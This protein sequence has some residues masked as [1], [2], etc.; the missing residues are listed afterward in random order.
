[1]MAGL[2]VHEAAWH[3][4]FCEAHTVAPSAI[5]IAVRTRP[6]SLSRMPE[7]MMRMDWGGA[8][9]GMLREIWSLRLSTVEEMG[10]VRGKEIAGL[11]SLMVRSMVEDICRE[12]GGGGGGGG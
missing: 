10:T 5:P 6:D 7:W 12:G 3:F 2:L 9:E 4:F 11:S 8:F 1:M